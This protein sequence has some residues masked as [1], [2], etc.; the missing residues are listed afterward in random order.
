VT[1]ARPPRSLADIVDIARHG[2]GHR[3][4]IA[5]GPIPLHLAG[6]H[7]QQLDELRISRRVSTPTGVRCM[8][9]RSP[10]TPCRSTTCHPNS[11]QS[12]TVMFASCVM[13]T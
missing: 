1:P 9:P 13:A 10:P 3:R 12:A 11:G 6:E 5:F 7:E 2:A 4:T 8:W